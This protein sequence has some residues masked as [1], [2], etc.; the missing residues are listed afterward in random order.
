MTFPRFLAPL[1]PLQAS[2]QLQVSPTG[3]GAAGS[4]QLTFSMQVQQQPNW[5]WAANTSSVS[6]FFM[7]SSTWTQ[8]SVADQCLGGGCCAAPSS[9]NDIYTLDVPLSQTGNLNA[10]AFAG[11]DARANIQAQI[12]SGNPVCCHI[13]WA[14][15]GGHFVALSGYDWTTDDVIVND[16]D[17]AYGPGPVPVP[18]DTFLSSYRGSGTWDYT[19]HTQA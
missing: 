6:T 15:G 1:M 8:C 3:G 17:S 11:V 18:Y 4:A 13:S 10:P 12:D 5:C 2:V 19:Y 16:P 9:C 7:P 14:G